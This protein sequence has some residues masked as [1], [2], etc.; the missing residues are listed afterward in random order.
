[1]ASAAEEAADIAV[2]VVVIKIA[3]AVEDGLGG[4]AT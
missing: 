4:P 2:D 3:Y 1:V